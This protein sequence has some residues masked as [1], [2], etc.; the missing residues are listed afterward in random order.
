MANMRLISFLF[1]TSGLF[2]AK[3]LR[4]QIMPSLEP[5]VADGV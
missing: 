3:D 4:H 2:Q 1:S 5:K